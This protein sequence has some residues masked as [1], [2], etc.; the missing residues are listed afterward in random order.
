M[1]GGVDTLQKISSASA[2]LPTPKYAVE[3]IINMYTPHAGRNAP[4]RVSKSHI[5]RTSYK[6]TQD[7][8]ASRC[9]WSR[10]EASVP[11]RRIIPLQLASQHREFQS[12]RNSAFPMDAATMPTDA[13]GCPRMLAHKKSSPR[14]CLV[15]ILLTR[16]P[17]RFC[18][19]S[20]VS[21]CLII[22]LRVRASS[23][24]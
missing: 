23:S 24:P 12:R 4:M 11:F 15:L 10:P 17:N 8:T 18:G 13:S 5:F 3:I 22:V 19:R 9:G 21:F 6:Q 1:V 2:M 14:G 16:P 20:S 7:A